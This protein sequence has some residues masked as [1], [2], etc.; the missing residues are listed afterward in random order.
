[1]A[2]ATTPIT[3]NHDKFIYASA[4]WDEASDGTAIMYLLSIDIS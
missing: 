1:L 3:T 4:T 2:G